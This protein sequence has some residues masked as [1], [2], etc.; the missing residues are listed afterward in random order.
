MMALPLQV[1]QVAIAAEAVTAIMV[2]PVATA[3]FLQA[4]PGDR[5]PR[6]AR[7]ALAVV[8]PTLDCQ[9]L[10]LLGL[11]MIGPVKAPIELGV[12]D[13]HCALPPK[14]SPVCTLPNCHVQPSSGSRTR[15]QYG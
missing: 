8:A 11:R 3:D 13:P 6:S 12:T 9:R 10:Q 1:G 15:A 4:A 14:F 5:A 2:A 7:A